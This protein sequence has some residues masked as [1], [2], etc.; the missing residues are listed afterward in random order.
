MDITTGNIDAFAAAKETSLV[1]KTSN[2]L[3][4]SSPLHSALL[5]GSTP[6]DVAQANVDLENAL[7]SRAGL[8]LIDPICSTPLSSLKGTRREFQKAHATRTGTVL[9]MS[10]L[11]GRLLTMTRALNNALERR[12]LWNNVVRITSV[13]G[14]LITLMTGADV[15]M[16]AATMETANTGCWDVSTQDWHRD[17]LMVLAEAIEAECSSGV[18]RGV[19]R[20]V[21]NAEALTADLGGKAGPTTTTATTTI[22]SSS[23]SSRFGLPHTCRISTVAI[24]SLIASYLSHLPSYNDLGLQLGAQQDWLIVPASTLVGD[25]D[26]IVVPNPAYHNGDD[27]DSVQPFL[28]LCRITGA[29]QA[30]LAV[31]NAYTNG[32]WT[33]FVRMSNV[34]C[35]GGSVGMDNKVRSAGRA[36]TTLSQP[37]VLICSSLAQRD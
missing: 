33:A 14:L 8:V 24:P 36:H 34:V 23:T 22:I 35:A 37:T 31:R 5:W 13:V 25:V 16:C 9:S 12:L 3:A 27:A 21:V 32:N 7:A 26:R 28:A 11:P 15:P 18:G 17:L 6:A 30:R 29:G 2:M 19:E 4:L 1:S 20:G 10:T